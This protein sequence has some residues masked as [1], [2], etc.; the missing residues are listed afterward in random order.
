MNKEPVT[1]WRIWSIEHR[2]WWGPNSCGY[3]RL[4][5][6]AGEY[7]LE[8]AVEICSGANRYRMDDFPPNE[9]MEP[10]TT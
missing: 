10:V 6:Q 5:S 3:V 9:A 2:G 7:T 8:E 1:K 4:K